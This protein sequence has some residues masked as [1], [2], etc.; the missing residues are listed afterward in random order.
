MP[1]RIGMSTVE[2]T[3][4]GKV[5]SHYRIIEKIGQ[6][7]LGEVFLAEDT[8]LTRRVAMKFLSRSDDSQ[9]HEQIIAEARSAAMIDHPYTCKVFEAGQSEGKSFIV[10]EYVEGETLSHRLKAGRLPFAEA[11]KIAG[12]VTEALADAHDKAIVH[13]DLKPANVMIART[14]HVKLMDFGLARIVRHTKETEDPT[15]EITS[16]GI[17]VAGTPAY[18]PPEQARGDNL[19]PRTDVFACGIILFEMVAGVHPFRRKTPQATIAAILHEDPPSL[20]QLVPSIS[21]TLA[22]I[23]YRCIAKEPD[24]RYATARELWT[25]LV[26][27]RRRE[28]PDND[29]QTDIIAPFRFSDADKVPAVAILPFTDFSP[30]KDLEYLCHGLAEELIIALDSVDGLNVASRTA[31]FRYKK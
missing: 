6:G 3:M 27:G 29:T 9:A 5:I 13:C 12:E 11:M 26:T 18:M 24:D 16:S 30:E 7:G 14:G 10:M 15:E 21:P 1:S 17:T 19:D 25:D 28:S 2:E 20:E 8:I 23:I 4:I 31:S 22:D